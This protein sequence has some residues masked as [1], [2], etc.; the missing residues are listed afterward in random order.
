MRASAALRRWSRRLLADRW[1]AGAVL[2]LALALELVPHPCTA[3]DVML[4]WTVPSGAAGYRAYTGSRSRTYN[5][6]TEI[7]SAGSSTLGGVV[8]HLYRGV[9]LGSALYVAVTAYDSAG[10][11]SDYSNEKVFKNAVAVPPLVDAGPNQSAP[12]GASV[13]LGSTPQNG[14]SYFWEQIAGPP[15]TFSSRTGSSTRVSAASV[16]TFIFVVTAYN[17]QAVA[18]RATVAVTFTGSGL[19]TPT[20]TL[21]G[22]RLPTPTSVPFSIPVG[23]TLLI[24]G[25]RRSPVKDRSSCQVEWTVANADGTIALDRFALPSVSQACEDGDPSC[26]SLPDQV[27]VCQFQV[28]VCLNNIDPSLPACLPNGVTE[29]KVLSPRPR[30][31]S[32]SKNNTILTADLSALQGALA[33]LQNPD[34][35]GAGYVNGIPLEAG[36]YGF[37][38][39]P[40]PIQ[41]WVTARNRPSVTLKTR[42][43][44][45]GLPRRYVSLSQL[46]LICKPSQQ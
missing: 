22:N 18:A 10:V 41:A 21:T 9:P 45:S 43:T 11:E 31:G 32:T 37:C 1:R 24:R 13:M 15:A 38:S 26:D 29:I 8:Y 34:N 44:V 19:P 14:V 17:A 35:P 4:R 3:Y 36:Q 46:Q 12:V 23:P 33:H 6:L 42:S 39:A 30:S 20:P 40:F 5:Q 7:P 16:G 2:A 27:G 25:N 28:R